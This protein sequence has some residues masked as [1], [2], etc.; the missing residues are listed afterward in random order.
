MNHIDIS[1]IVQDFHH[2]VSVNRNIILSGAFGS[3]K[4]YMIDVFKRTYSK[5]FN[6]ITIYPINYA[7]SD[8][9]DIMEYI[10][11]DIIYQLVLLG[12]ISEKTDFETLSSVIFTTENAVKMTSYL[13]NNIPGGGLI[14]AAIKT[15]LETK[16][17]YDSKKQA[18][19]SYLEEFGKA[20]SIYERDVYTEMIHLGLEEGRRDGKQWMLI[21]EDLDRIDPKNIFRLLNVFGAHLDCHYITGEESETNKFG[22]DKLVFVLDYVQTC[23]IYNQYFGLDSDDSW[24]GYISKF[25]T[26]QPFYFNG[27][28]SVAA[29]EVFRSIASE[30][31]LSVN[32]VEKIFLE[33]YSIRTFSMRT[34]SKVSSNGFESFLR[35]DHIDLSNGEILTADCKLTRLAFYLWQLNGRINQ[36]KRIVADTVDYL[37]LVAPVLLY[38]HQCS[39]LCVNFSRV[40]YFLVTASDGVTKVKKIKQSSLLRLEVEIIGMDTDPRNFTLMAIEINGF[41]EKFTR[42]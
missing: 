24:E 11:R 15:A 27:V 12:Y 37:E 31:R 32:I 3:G 2:H 17:S 22:F 38:Q 9:T 23:N 30:C 20:G 14:A 16:E 4:S 25:L 29:K 13:L 6:T 5:E 19:S 42:Y 18:V 28:S 26:S 33:E 34:L 10:K 36:L 35:T 1:H 39:S 21:I 7:I 40:G 41:L 8:N